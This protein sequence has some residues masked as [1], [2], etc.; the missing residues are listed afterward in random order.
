MTP[1][2]IVASDLPAALSSSTSINGTSIPASV[3]LPQVIV[4]GSIAM[5]VTSV[6]A[7]SCD[8]AATLAS[9]GTITA[10]AIANVA[11]TDNPNANYNSDQTLIS[12]YNSG[13]NIQK[14]PESGDIGFKR[15]NVTA[16]PITPGAATL[17]FQV[18]R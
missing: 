9:T 15:C 13:V 5:P 10:G 2:A 14:F 6:A 8:A 3:T 11:T 18:I 16:S 1:R 7:N 12:G 17:N 4:E